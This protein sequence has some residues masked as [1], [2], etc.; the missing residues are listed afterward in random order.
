MTPA[1]PSS[2]SNPEAATRLARQTRLLTTGLLLTLIGLG[3]AWEL[4]LAPLRPGGSWWAIKVLPL[5]LALPG[6]L[7]HRMYTHRWLS[8]LVWFYITEGLVRGTSESGLSAG[9]AW[10]EVLLSLGLFVA[11]TAHIRLRLRH[12]KAH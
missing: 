12:A 7:K 10:L 4:W 11:S 3:L 8:L 2:P 1:P 6:L 9:L 5:T